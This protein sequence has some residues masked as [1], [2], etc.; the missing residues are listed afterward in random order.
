MIGSS[1]LYSRLVRSGTGSV[2]VKAC[3]KNLFFS[4]NIRRYQKDKEEDYE[5]SYSIIRSHIGLASLPEGKEKEG[6]SQ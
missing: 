2:L 1:L 3:S 5:S 4:V 6:K